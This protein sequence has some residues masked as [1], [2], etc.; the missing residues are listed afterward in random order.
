MGTDRMRRLHAP[1]LGLLGVALMVA[2]WAL[3]RV[4]GVLPETDIPSPS[5]VF[6]ALVDAL[7]TAA[8]W[9]D[10]GQ[11]VR[12][13]FLG[14]AIAF[15]ITLP[16]SIA[17]G[18]LW[19]VNAALSPLVQFL[20]P[21]PGV[22]LLPVAVLLFGA[23]SR[24]DVALVAWG[25]SWPLLVQLTNGFRGAPRTSL[26]T[27]RAFGLGLAAQVRW[28]IVPA[29]MPFVATGLRIGAS[30][31]LIIAI[32]A[33]LIAGSPGLGSAIRDAQNVLDVDSMYALIL[34]TGVVGVCFHVALAAG[35][36]HYLRWQPSK[37]GRR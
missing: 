14:L 3:L 34:A 21:V 4:V 23:T 33:E 29:A 16:L 10:L 12:S 37:D 27:A 11:T 2:A 26:M 24:M 31:A 35:E 17:M 30:I 18:F 5:A 32:S 28:V 1:A 22:A 19:P 8:F 36:R 15:A 7:G 6:A 20:R 9:T 25:C 13:A